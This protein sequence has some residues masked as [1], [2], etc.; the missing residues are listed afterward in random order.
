MRISLITA[1]RRKSIVIFFLS[2]HKTGWLGMADRLV[3]MIDCRRRKSSM[4]YIIITYP[5][6]PHSNES[7]NVSAIHAGQ[8]HT[9]II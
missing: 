6:P 8:L 2:Y 9:S 7:L 4:R 1:R 3:A 5:V